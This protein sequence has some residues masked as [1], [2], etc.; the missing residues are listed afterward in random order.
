MTGRYYDVI[1]LGRSPGA[2]LAAAL[3]ARR[4]FSVFVAGHTT[5][6]ATYSYEGHAL[7][8]RAFSLL[9]APSPALRRAL[10]ELAQSQTFRRR[11]VALDPMLTVLLPGRRFE[12]APDLALFE[13]EMDRE[14]PEVRRVL[15]ELYTTLARVNESTDL[16]FTRDLVWP[17]GSFWERQRASRALAQ[18]PFAREG[19]PDVLA[20]LPPYHPY[21][22]V[23]DASVA[24]ASDLA[25]SRRPLPPFAAARLH[26][27]WTRGVVAFA[28]GEDELVQFLVDRI[29]AHGGIVAL[30]E[31]VERVA[32][33]RD[34]VQGVFLEGDTT[35]TGCQFL[36]TTETGEELAALAGGAGVSGRAQRHWP[37][38]TPTLGRFVLSLVVKREGVPDPLGAESI[39]FGQA[40]G[41]PPDPRRPTLRLQRTDRMSGPSVMGGASG[42]AGASVA[43]GASP[44]EHVLLV[45]ETILPLPPA[46]GGLPATEAREAVLGTLRMHLPWLEQHLVAC[47]SPHDGRA[48]WFYAQGERREIDRIH[49]RGA[50]LRAEPM[51]PLYDVDPPSF[52]GLGGEPLRGPIGRTF[53][54]GKSVLPALGQEGELLASVSAARLVT[55]SDPR[56][57]RLR[58]EMWNRVEIG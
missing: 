50:S 54:V 4:D 27:A 38:V 58:L 26:G 12:I 7:R 39:V 30:N 21:R 11:T 25:P 52:F 34:G 16:A 49:V 1:V 33:G 47:D 46:R 24:F 20:D 44:P 22:A 48:L 10:V 36:L 53:L 41:S 8:R 35:R 40:P 23:V 9:G 29:T 37:R 5:K 42:A 3:L 45:A 19:G 6:P 57:E 55:K 2:L 28:G 15:D 32:A 31:R 18:L 43:T 56:R 13:R 51:E 17:P 14:F